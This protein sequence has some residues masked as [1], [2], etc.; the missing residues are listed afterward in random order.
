MEERDYRV[1]E[2]MPR[3]E[4]DDLR[5]FY[6][7][8]REEALGM[9]PEIEL[10]WLRS[11]DDLTAPFALRIRVFCDEQGYAPGDGTGWN[12]RYG[13]A[14]A[15]VGRRNAGGN[16]AAVLAQRGGRLYGNRPFG[17]GSGV[18][19]PRLR[20]H[21]GEGNGKRAERMGASTLLLDAQTRA[22]GF[23]EKLGYAVCGEE[24]MDG[25]VPHKMMKKRL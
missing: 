4:V 12:G 9:N 23:Y 19:R 22:I 15:A 16:R 20:Q 6:R 2:R 5:P 11:P 13:L 14:F 8:P 24:H 7:E 18:A 21:T 3:G 10:R 1:C 25:H 17:G